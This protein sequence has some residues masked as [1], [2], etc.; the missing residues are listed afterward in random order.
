MMIIQ[1]IA[2]GYLRKFT[3]SHASL[4][5]IEL[6]EGARVKDLIS[7][8]ELSDEESFIVAVNGE[9][10]P[11]GHVLHQN[12]QVRLVPPVSGG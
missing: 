1:V 3:Q 4:A 5:S 2:S 11:F 7:L 10:V 9:L 6:Q 8:L 12:D